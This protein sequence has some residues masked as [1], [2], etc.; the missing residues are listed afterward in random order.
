MCCDCIVV[1][2]TT[3]PTKPSI[4]L[5]HCPPF[6][7]FLFSRTLLQ[8]W[9][10]YQSSQLETEISIG[11]GNGRGSRMGVSTLDA[12]HGGRVYVEGLPFFSLQLQS[13]E[14]EHRGEAKWR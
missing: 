5:V 2:P 6:H 8:K 4:F 9:T 3:T 10:I 7:S 12:E 13:R 1:F 14:V 11:F